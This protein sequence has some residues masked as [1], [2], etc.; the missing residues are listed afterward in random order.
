MAITGTMG[1]RITQLR[2]E[3]RMS[4]KDLADFLY[5]NQE[6]V[7]RWE[8]GVRFPDDDLIV[9]MAKRFG[10]DPDVLLHPAPEPPIVILVDDEPISLEV[11]V[12]NVQTI[13]VLSLTKLQRLT[14]A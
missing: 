1:E 13:Q 12:L 9:K 11:N 10:V 4:Q 7:S 14:I 8:R 6:T 3:S 5:V 2:I